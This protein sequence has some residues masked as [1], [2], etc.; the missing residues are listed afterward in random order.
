MFDPEICNLFGVKHCVLKDG[1]SE[2][3][4]EALAAVLPN[5]GDGQPLPQ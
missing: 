1:N 4:S 3:L 2:A 5:G